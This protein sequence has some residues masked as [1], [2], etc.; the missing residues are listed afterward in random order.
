M[1]IHLRQVIIAILLVFVSG[2]SQA[3]STY[4]PDQ[5]HF[6]SLWGEM[7]VSTLLNNTDVV[8]AKGGFSPAIGVGYRFYSDKF[9]MQLGAEFAYMYHSNSLDNADIQLR[10]RDTEDDLF[11]LHA[12]VDKC[13]DITQT[14][15]LQIPLL[16]GYE[17]NKFYFLAGVNLGLNLTGTTSSASY[18]T[19]TATYDDLEGVWH[20]MENHYLYNNKQ[21]SSQP[22]PVKWNFN[23]MGHVELGGRVDAFSSEKGADVEMHN[24]RMYLSAFAEYGIL[25]VHQN[26]SVGSALDYA[27]VPGEGLKFFVVPAL[28]SDQMTDSKVNPLT[29]GIKFTVAFALPEKKECVICNEMKRKQHTQ[30][31]DAGGHVSW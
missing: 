4:N 26:S 15:H 14:T 11:T 25:N 22:Y 23:V 12:K 5:S 8:K 13:K 9:I 7:G 2:V 10:M 31:Y 16:F 19:T 17:R 3:R 24:Y 20:D 30:H 29:V 1:K 18:L 21:V 27:E 28:V 6:I